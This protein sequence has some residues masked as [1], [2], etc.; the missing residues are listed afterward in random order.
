MH[1]CECWKLCCFREN[2]EFFSVVNY[3]NLK[4]YLHNIK[5][6]CIIM[7]KMHKKIKMIACR[8]FTNHLF[9][10]NIE[11]YAVLQEK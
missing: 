8:H 4:K 2:I 1:E 7:Q 6:E 10:T 3:S 9:C 5:Y 11:S